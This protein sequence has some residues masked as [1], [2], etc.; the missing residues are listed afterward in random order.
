MCDEDKKRLKQYVNVIHNNI[1]YNY[2]KMQINTCTGIMI[3]TFK[4]DI[5]L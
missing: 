3:Q 2:Y 4:I 5:D 1:I